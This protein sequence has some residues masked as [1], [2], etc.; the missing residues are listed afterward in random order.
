MYRPSYTPVVHKTFL[1][2]LAANST[3]I[4][5]IL[6]LFTHIV[7]QLIVPL[8][9]P[10]TRRSRVRRC[11][12]L[13]VS[14]LVIASTIMSS[15]NVTTTYGAR[16]NGS[17]GSSNIA[18]EVSAEATPG[19][20]AVTGTT[21]ALAS[22][23][24]TSTAIPTLPP[25]AS[26]TPTAASSVQATG[27]LGASSTTTPFGT[28]TLAATVTATG[29]ITPTPPPPVERT[30]TPVL[31]PHL[32][33]LIL[34]ADFSQRTLTVGD[35]FTAT[36]TIKN[37][38]PDPADNVIVSMSVPT[39]TVAYPN[40]QP[41]GWTWQLARVEGRGS[42]TVTA[43]MR[44]LSIPTGS[45]V[46]VRP[47]VTASGLSIPVYH[48]SGTL[49][50]P[51][52]LSPVTVPF[53]PG[54]PAILRGLDGR[55]EI[56]VPG[57][58]ANRALI[59]RHGFQPLPGG[60]VPPD[61]AGRKKGLG[62]F[63]L[64]ATDLLG[65]EFHEF[66]APLTVTLQ[67]TP[68]QLQ[69]L[70]IAEGDLTLFWFDES[71]PDGGK[72]VP[73]TT[74]VD[75]ETNTVTATVTHF[76][77]FQ[78]SD[79]SSP[80]SAYIPS[81]EGWQVG[82]YTGNVSYQYP[83][84]VPAGPAGIKPN[85][86]LSYDSAA[87]DGKSGE[88]R[89]QQS[90]WVGQ[91][92]SL[93]SGYVALNKLP[94]EDT[95]SRYYSLVFN[96]QSFDL[97]RGAERADR[98]CEP[99]KPC[100]DIKNPSHWD[101]RPTNESFIKVKVERNGDSF[102]GPPGR[103]GFRYIGANYVR[104]PLQRFKWQVWTKDG[105]R[106]DF[107]EDMWQGYALD[108][109]SSRSN[110]TEAYKW[111]MTRVE[112]SHGNRINYSYGRE[113]QWRDECT[114]D[115]R[116]R[117]TGTIDGSIWPTQITWGGNI[118]GAPDRYKV[119]FQTSWRSIDTD[120]EATDG[121]LNPVPR[122]SQRLDAI[123][124][125]SMQATTWELVRQYN[126]R[127]ETGTDPQ[128]YL[129]SDFSVDNGNGTYGKDYG[130]QKLTLLGITRVANNGSTAL[131][132]TT[133][134]YHQWRGTGFYP[135]GL[136]NR[137][138]TVNNGQG[139]VVTFTY[140]NIGA[141]HYP[142]IHNYPF[143]NNRRVT[144]K[145]VTDG[146][147]NSY[148]WTYSYQNP[149]YNSV[150]TNLGGPGTNAL[151]NSASIYFSEWRNRDA[152]GN[153]TQATE[154]DR[155]LVVHKQ[156]TQFRGHSYAIERDP[157]GN[158]TEHWFYQ[159]DAG[160][161]PN[162]GL[163]GEAILTDS[164]FLLI[165]DREFLTGREWKTITH[166]G[167]ATDPKL[168]EVQHAF[169]TVP[170]SVDYVRNVSDDILSGLWRHFTYDSQT[171]E[172][173]WE[174]GTNPLSKTTD[175]LYDLNTYGNLTEVTERD[176]A[177]GSPVLRKTIYSYVTRNDATAYIVDRKRAERIFDGQNNLIA[178]TIYGY[179][180]SNGESTL[181][182]RG[183]LTLV[184]KYYD[185]AVPLP[186]TI[187]SS[188]TS[189][190]YDNYGNQT[191]VTT[192]AGPGEGGSDGSWYSAPGAPY[193]GNSIPR[194]TT[195]I[196]EPAN[197]NPPRTN[198]PAFHSFPLEVRPPAVNGVVLVEKGYYDYRM[199]TLSSVT[200]PNNQTTQAEYDL[201]GRMSKLIKPGDSSTYPTVQNDYYDNEQ[202]FKFIAR[203][204]EQQG[205]SN[206][207]PILSFYD[208]LGRKIQTKAQSSTTHCFQHIVTDMQYDGLGQVIRQSQPR[209]VETPGGCYPTT[210][211]DY[212]SPGASLYRPTLTTYDGLGRPT[213]VTAPD[214]TVTHLDYWINTGNS[215][216]VVT[217]VDAK[218][219]GTHRESD[220]FGRLRGVVEL[221]G[222]SPNFTEYSRTSYEYSSL[223]LLTTV[224]DTKTKQTTIQY[225]SLGRKKQMTD[226][227]MGTWQYGYDVNGNLTSQ[228]DARTLTIGFQYDE[229][230]RLTRKNYPDGS[231]A[232]YVY[233]EI[234]S[235]NGK[236][237]RTTMRK[238]RSGGGVD[239]ITQSNYDARGQQT[240]WTTTID[241]LPARTFSQSYDSAGRT[242]SITYPNNEV[243][244][245]T[246]D[247]AWRQVS[248]CSNQYTPC[249]SSNATYTP[250]DQPSNVSLGNGL[251][252]TYQ[253]NNS[254]SRLSQLQVG[255]NG[256]I[257]Y[258]TYTYDNVG[259]VESITNPNNNNQVQS[260]G[261]D[262][263][264]RLTDWGIPN[265]ISQT[266]TYDEVGN[267]LSK[268]GVTYDY[269][270][271]SHAYGGG[272]PYAVRNTGY[273]YD[274]NGNMTNMPGNA[275]LTWNYD[276]QPIQIA[277]NGATEQY[278]YDADNERVKRTV[279]GTGVATYTIGGLYEEDVPA[280]GQATTRYMYTING[281]VIAQRE[282]APD[283]PTATPTSTATS[284]PTN[285]P[286]PGGCEAISWTSLVDV[287]VEGNLSNTIM[288]DMLGNG[289]DAGAISTNLITALE[290]TAYVKATADNTFG[291][292][293]FGLGI[294]NSSASYDDIDFAVELQAGGGVRVYENGVLKADQP[295]SYQ[296]SDVFK[297]SLEYDASY[298]KNVV[299]WYKNGVAFY[300]NT[301]PTISYP[302]VL[303]TSIYSTGAKVY[304][305]YMC[306]QPGG[307]DQPRSGNG[308]GTGNDSRTSTK[309][310]TTSMN[311]NQSSPTKALTATATASKGGNTGKPDGP[312]N[313]NVVNTLIYLHADHLGSV[314]A[315][316]SSSG[317]PVSS[318]EFDPWGK[319]RDPES[320]VAQ[321]KLNYTGQ[322]LDGTGL[323]FYSARYYDPQ[324]AR[325][326]SPDAII[327]GTALGYGGVL[328]TVGEWQHSKLA[329]DFHETSVVTPSN[330][331]NLQTLK[332]GFSFEQSGN[333]NLTGGPKNPQ[334]LNRYAYVDNNPLSYTDPTGHGK[335][336]E[337]HGGNG[338]GG[339][340]FP[341]P[342]PKAIEKIRQWLVG[343]WNN[344]F[345]SGSAQ[346]SA[347]V[348]NAGSSGLKF[349]ANELVYGPSAGGRLAE[350]AQRAGGKTL[351]D[352]MV[353]KPPSM[354]VID[355]SKKTLDQAAAIG[356]R[357]HFDLTYVDDL[358]NVLKN[359]GPYANTITGEELRYIYANWDRFGKL[360]TFYVNGVP[361]KP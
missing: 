235:T 123:K 101:W 148:P 181:G 187:H 239:S 45:A 324:L 168:S 260:F 32:P 185:V 227:T 198:E 284:T 271:Y 59:L 267:I 142:T 205:T 118:N 132:E 157:S 69:A 156:S 79:G 192:Y 104:T 244:S 112:D 351:N 33:S 107:E 122:E 237:Q 323:L 2:S 268:A 49:V 63:Y 261:Y 97:V 330:R 299:R 208:G 15:L 270:N 90:S 114:A 140:D 266:Y 96:G 349:G 224:I 22:A 40:P 221:S 252:Q 337:P 133:F 126:L 60:R 125:K 243:V 73:I 161:T 218:G 131:P 281:N 155:T 289:W 119:E 350:L 146:R 141:F 35:L 301:N 217:T 305:A 64:D 50:M 303:D 255:T 113:S 222:T 129:L 298:K 3:I 19:I 103:G 226:P 275:V 272:G 11:V 308:S 280:N 230:G 189:Y 80:S 44:L 88:R 354:S 106:F 14:A 234:G 154:T 98:V 91:G 263:R 74:N 99:Y 291:Y 196:Y 137:L 95:Q 164:C 41:N 9:R 216:Q 290:G 186:A 143:R 110:F 31:D 359:T 25:S 16:A 328:G 265:V 319:V 360:V 47:Q 250:L 42:M 211:W 135:N 276:N 195:T 199:G 302:L 34:D 43:T 253:Y 258:R 166:Q 13:F 81:L 249:Y 220:M 102:E 247:G 116:F 89:L 29:S 294:G 92:W 52:N 322:K 111:H 361:I 262:H 295:T 66:S 306:P 317:S 213:D 21:T 48:Q 87:T 241:G 326:V 264:D 162:T 207:R 283:A 188:D 246:Y 170:S 27:T 296:A 356:T 215:R 6:S 175:S 288:K 18:S 124:V 139:G 293:M 245:Y 204:R 115:N 335:T 321:T 85:V 36:L 37:Q 150:G 4:S 256:S 152:N 176:G 179:D 144:S 304:D 278:V 214:N 352:L 225:D 190:G 65:Q 231:Y 344:V 327:P 26:L 28:S 138:E 236:G 232:Q 342:D 84:D 201:F 75:P 172:T 274:A 169:Y 297:V 203:L 315:A 163:R 61:T 128:L 336:I 78:F 292:K 177:P 347:T 311:T 117:V 345:G 248:A 83:I 121:Q 1:Q 251:A 212:V 134:A 206:Y 62:T 151:P 159:G 229:L 94:G 68:E 194:V 8:I 167:L 76:S 147:G 105:T 193:G 39:G 269:Q 202:P 197:T 71:Q 309:T 318:Q 17:P 209:Y 314:S 108:C 120:G 20:P 313:P 173:A 228:V 180:N 171:V 242:T 24:A 46:V 127:F 23:T 254:M 286:L 333:V 273:D 184:R 329:V 277:K 72:W 136:W 279:T 165:R 67:Y 223:D 219:H 307:S 320:Q 183:L 316:T 341:P 149:A 53:T 210:F 7:E 100:P 238:V 357:I 332:E 200:D 285:T 358:Q 38:A 82:L 86:A 338:G 56:R 312:T 233:D 70:G 348:A 310:S 174:K 130:T 5:L 54:L 340:P 300:T 55:S 334:T 282:I 178:R 257:F 182:T 93:D 331:E 339:L 158:E 325:F 287:S 58:A 30:V 57:N 240:N 346:R 160:C 77:A 353:S 109:G 191:T 153:V 343:T 355:F 12:Q 51:P 10:Q 145:T 259:N